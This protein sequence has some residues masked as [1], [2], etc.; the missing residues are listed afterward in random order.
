M[1][2]QS[3]AR[4]AADMILSQVRNYLVE[5]K[6]VALTDMVYRFDADADALRGMLAILQRKGKVRLLPPAAGCDR[7]CGK[8]DAAS[9]E[10]FEWIEAKDG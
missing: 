9:M 5:H 4:E 7:G 6:R 3:T 2:P 10:V 1:R 8:C